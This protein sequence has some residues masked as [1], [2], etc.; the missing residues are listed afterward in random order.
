MLIYI[1]AAHQSIK[2]CINVDTY[3]KIWYLRVVSINSNNSNWS[4]TLKV[5]THELKEIIIV[6]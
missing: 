2:E 6:L 4:K 5:G 3:T 1:Q